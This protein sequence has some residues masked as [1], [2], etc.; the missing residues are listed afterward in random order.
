MDVMQALL[1]RRSIRV[2]KDQPIS[3]KQLQRILRAGMYAPSAVD[4]RPWVFVV[5]RDRARLQG[6]ANDLDGMEMLKTAHMAILV[7]GDIERE[8][9]PGYWVQD[10]SACTQNI[11]LAA[12]A[13]GLGAVWVAVDFLSR[14][15]PLRMALQL[16]LS[17]MPLALVP[18]GYPAEEPKT[19][20]RYEQQR[21]YE[22]VWKPHDS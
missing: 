9:L 6:W 22:E 15:E 4:Q 21:V 8:Q 17:V 3:Q 1:Q 14:S 16:P 7:C 2:F 5:I 12:H 18:V 10:C 13:E 11:L 19:S 20:D